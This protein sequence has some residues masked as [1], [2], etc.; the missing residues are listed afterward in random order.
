[1]RSIVGLRAGGL[2]DMRAGKR[3]DLA[4]MKAEKTY[5]GPCPCCSRL[6]YEKCCQRLHEGAPAADAEALMRSRYT[7]FVLK[8][9]DYLVETWHPSTRPTDLDV[10]AWKRRWLALKVLRHEVV[11]PTEASVEFIARFRG[12]GRSID[13]H[14]TS[15]FFLENGRWYYVDG[16]IEGQPAEQAAEP[17]KVSEA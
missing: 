16:V 11:S 3:K 15:R 17:E 14:E 8:L 13:M 1:M 10:H 7:A 6:T 2:A 4:D 9:Q 5:R 12:P